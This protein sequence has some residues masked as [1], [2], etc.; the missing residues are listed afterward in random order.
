MA[1]WTLQPLKKNGVAFTS[2]VQPQVSAGY[3]LGGMPAPSASYTIPATPKTSTYQ[4]GGWTLAPMP[5]TSQAPT[6]ATGYSTSTLGALGGLSGTSQGTSTQGAPSYQ[7]PAYDPGAS[8]RAIAPTSTQGQQSWTSGST[9]GNPYGTPQAQ[10]FRGALSQPGHY[11]NWYAQNASRYNQPTALSSYYQSVSGKL[12]GQR[13]QP[14]NS[15]GAYNQ[16]QST[17]SQPSYGMNNAQD[18]SQQLRQTSQGEGYMGQAA[19]MFGGPN[20]AS[21]YFSA[22]QDF[23]RTPGDIESFYR[24]NAGMFENAGYGEGLSQEML[25][26][27]P[28]GDVQGMLNQQMFGDQAIADMQNRSTNN[29]R[30]SSVYNTNQDVTGTNLVGAELD[31]FRDPLRAQSYSEQLYESGN[32]GLNTFY[33][34]ENQKAQ[35]ALADRMAAM[36]VFGSGETVQGMAEIDADLGAAQARDMAGLAQQADQQRLAR[37][38][39][40][41]GMASA[42]GQEE[43]ARRDLLR[44]MGVDADN[45]ALGQ[46]GLM[47]DAYGLASQ[48]GLGKIDRYLAGQN[49]RLGAIDRALA[50]DQLGLDRLGLGAN[51]ANMS[52]RYGLD[53]TN[54]GMDAASAADA[55]RWQ[56]AQGLANTG[57]M[58]SSAELARL[59]GSADIGL[60]R[61]AEERARM[62]SMFGAA[63]GLDRSY[64][65]AQAADLDWLTAGAD[66]AQGVDRGNLDWL[67]A[68]GRAADRAQQSY[69]TR[70]RYGFL[71][72]LAAANAMSGAYGNMAGTNTTEQGQ[73][74]SQAINLLMQKH[75][76]SA[77]EAQRRADE[78]AQTG[79]LMVMLATL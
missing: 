66:M 73:M 10:Q 32:Q 46:A 14:T 49:T 8:Q 78:W 33:D 75:G 29:R 26:S 16:L 7:Q 5:A 4:S 31:Y 58:M 60:A 47:M 17:Y 15:Q 2:T 70:E 77:A 37:A 43:L 9:G 59:T 20:Q 76:L 72:P 21:D 28:W 62:D 69:E 27:T 1:T 30:A 51:V 45:I 50:T 22:N 71:D 55:S 54:S 36:G 19:G 12:Q 67:D 40:L 11:E 38:D 57:N 18:V 74:R 79:Q 6:S 53:R 24:N 68:G 13:F 34:R 44:Q 56:Q 25:G 41:T 61:D 63:Q 3:Q 35:Q 39:Q 52:S 48:E 42:A 65:D 64:L 23:Y